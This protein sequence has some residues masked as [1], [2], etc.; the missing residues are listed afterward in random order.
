[1]AKKLIKVINAKQLLELPIQEERFIIF[2][3]R[4]W[5]GYLCEYTQDGGYFTGIQ[6]VHQKNGWF[7][8]STISGYKPLFSYDM[9][10][11]MHFSNRDAAVG[12]SKLLGSGCSVVRLVKT[13]TTEWI[14]S[15]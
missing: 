12:A 15:A 7:K 11:A 10:K 2:R 13:I 1:M 6:N 5:D 9:D 4:K 14:Q 8:Q 3:D